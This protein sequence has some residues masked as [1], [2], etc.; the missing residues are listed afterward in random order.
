MC[1]YIYRSKGEGKRALRKCL[2]SGEESPGVR[3]AQL[4]IIRGVKLSESIS[5]RPRNQA[6]DDTRAIAVRD[7]RFSPV[8][9]VEGVLS[10]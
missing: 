8:D 4:E 1:T 10:R 2:F 6:C 3:L 9:P 7:T 5:R